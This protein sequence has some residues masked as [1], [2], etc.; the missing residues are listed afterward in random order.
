MIIMKLGTSVYIDNTVTSTGFNI[1]INNKL[2]SIP[3]PKQIWKRFPSALKKPFSDALSV[4]VTR[5]FGYTKERSLFYNFPAPSPYPLFYQG[6]LYSI[7]GAPYEFPDNQWTIAELLKQAYNSE[8]RVSFSGIPYSIPSIKPHTLYPTRVCI[9]FSF[10]KDSLLAFALLRKFNYAVTP[11]YLQE[12]SS[13]DEIN[14]KLELVKKFQRMFS[15]PIRTIPLP[16]G[17]LREA[18]GDMWGWD[19]LLLQYSL[20]LLPYLFA[21]RCQYFVWSNE[22]NL[23]GTIKNPEGYLI[24]PTFDQTAHWTLLS[25]TMLRSFFINTQ[26]TSIVEPLYEMVMLS[27]LHHKFSEIGSFQLSCDVPKKPKKGHRWCGKCHECARQYILMLG[28]GVNPKRVGLMEDMLSI[29]KINLHHFFNHYEEKDGI[30]SQFQSE[31]ERKLAFYLAYKRGVKG[32]LI[33]QFKKQFLPEIEAK[34]NQLINTYFSVRSSFGMP[35][36]LKKILLPYYQKEMKRI[37]NEVM[38]NHLAPVDKF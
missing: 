18:G 38:S 4:F 5:H 35:D 6:Y 22:Q 17:A 26:M 28:A 33:S 1:Y 7:A 27:L 21:G 13:S 15:Q 11:I 19:L 25:N 14:I 8:F 37:R 9:P 32:D 30:N 36:E 16:L 34:K 31:T 20:F 24:N 23:T 2:I 29:K 10:G 3:Y 12:P